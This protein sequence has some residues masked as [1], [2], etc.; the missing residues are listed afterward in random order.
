M[1]G[2]DGNACKGDD[3][4]KDTPNQGGDND[5]SSQGAPNH[6]VIKF[7]HISCNNGPDGDM[8]MNYMDYVDDDTM[9]MFT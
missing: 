8:F 3:R 2:D 6:P 7:P 4:V 5:G 1:W 9:V